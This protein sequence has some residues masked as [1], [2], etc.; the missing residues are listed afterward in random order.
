MGSNPTADIFLSCLLSPTRRCVIAFWS[1]TK[2]ALDPWK[3]NSAMVGAASAIH[4]WTAEVS[5]VRIPDARQ[6]KIMLSNIFCRRRNRNPSSPARGNSNPVTSF[7]KNRNRGG[8]AA[9]V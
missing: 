5:Y 9:D 6:F 1:I 2:F 8:R 3:K 7:A 4:V